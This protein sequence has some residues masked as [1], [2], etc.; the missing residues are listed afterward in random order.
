M[1]CP[2]GKDKVNVNQQGLLLKRFIIYYKK[3]SK[4][5]LKVHFSA[6]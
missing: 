3:S 2:F 6:G 4:D 1:E 5:I